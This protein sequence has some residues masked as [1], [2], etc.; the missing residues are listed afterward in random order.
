MRISL[1]QIRRAAIVLAVLGMLVPHHSEAGILSSAI[2]GAMSAASQGGKTLSTVRNSG[3]YQRLKG[4]VSGAGRSALSRAGGLSTKAKQ[5][6]ANSGSLQRL[7]QASG[8]ARQA[9]G[10]VNQQFTQQ[11][12]KSGMAGAFGNVRQSASNAFNKATTNGV[13]AVQQ[14]LGHALE[15]NRSVFSQF[16]QKLPLAMATLAAPNGNQGI[17]GIAAQGQPLDS[18]GNLATALKAKAGIQGA[19]LPPAVTDRLKQSEVLRAI[20]TDPRLSN[21][22][23]QFMNKLQAAGVDVTKLKADLNKALDPNQPL[24][25]NMQ[26]DLANLLVDVGIVPKPPDG[27]DPVGPG[28]V[29]PPNNGGGGNP[30][31]GNPPAPPAN[32]PMNPPQATP[33]PWEQIVSDIPLYLA[34]ANGLG[35]GEGG[36]GV[37]QSGPVYQQASVEAAPAAEPAVEETAAVDLILEDVQLAAPATLVAG[38]AYRVTLRNQSTIPVGRFHVA[39]MAGLNGSLPESAPQAV[40]EIALLQPGEGTS[41]LLRLPNTA[42][43]MVAG[44]QVTPFTHLFIAADAMDGI[45]EADETNNTAILDRMAL[46]GAGK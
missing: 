22:Q 14:N 42:M 25:P 19:I 7:T 27:F 11:L 2:G 20:V 45:V 24:G 6:I 13:G 46:E 3:T 43:R 5:T 1:K 44:E 40:T 18:L 41:V 16:Q 9:L 23:T 4:S 38:P 36:G 31:P 39:V 33:F 10:N 28:N 29:V 17:A 30:A 34:L 37:T 21:A 15:V 32:P 35:G 8:T 26:N 12:S